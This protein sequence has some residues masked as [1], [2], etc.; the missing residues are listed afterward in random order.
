MSFLS[1]HFLLCRPVILFLLFFASSSSHLLPGLFM[2]LFLFVSSSLPLPGR[3]YSSSLFLTFLSFLSG[4]SSF[5]HLHFVSSHAWRSLHFSV[6]SPPC[7]LFVSPLFFF[8]LFHISVLRQAGRNGVSWVLHGDGAQT[9]PCCR[10]D[11]FLM[12]M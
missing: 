11:E 5:L 6:S 9:S 3:L 1:S 8:I 12:I 4:H 2:S 10:R 7:C